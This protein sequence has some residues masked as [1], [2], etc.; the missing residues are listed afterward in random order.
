M[1][2]YGIQASVGIYTKSEFGVFFIIIIFF[3][4]FFFWVNNLNFSL[5]KYIFTIFL[6][7]NTHTQR[8]KTSLL[9]FVTHLI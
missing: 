1:C 3:C 9:L 2:I 5:K 6:E 8:R 4:L 7:T